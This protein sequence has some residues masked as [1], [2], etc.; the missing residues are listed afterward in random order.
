MS[1]IGKEP[2][3]SFISFAKQDFST[4]ATTSYTL[5]HPVANQN[6]IALFINFVRQEPTTAYTAS[7][8]SLTLTSAT[9][10][11][12]DMYCIY[13]GKAVQTV[14]P[15]NSS[16]GTSQ[17]D[18]SLDFSSKTITLASNMKNTPAF[19]VYGSSGQSL[20]DNTDTKVE[21]DTEVYDT[22][23][24]FA[25]HKFTVP[26]AG[27]YFFN[28]NLYFEGRG[29][30]DYRRFQ[31]AYRKNGGGLSLPSSLHL[32]RENYSNEMRANGV[33]FSIILDLAVS[34]YV[35]VYALQDNSAN[36]SRQLEQAY[37]QG[38]KLIG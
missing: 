13:L 38:F 15:P 37:F 29:E 6:E 33:S 9:A 12:D 32:A 20:S 11:S 23:S 8:T 4:S 28:V 21:F 3:D 17:L 26:S 14:N 16:V 31:A 35:E 1:Y 22:D 10:S 30:N 5:D 2:A 19:A 24:A 27:K 18:S 7:G 36:A 34:D 25:S